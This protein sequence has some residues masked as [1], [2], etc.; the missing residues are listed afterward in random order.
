[1]AGDAVAWFVLRWMDR[2]RSLE[3]GG[4]AGGGGGVVRFE[5]GGPGED[6]GGGGLAG[7]AVG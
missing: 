2:G 5:M 3:A 1:M 6:V 4:L 7:D